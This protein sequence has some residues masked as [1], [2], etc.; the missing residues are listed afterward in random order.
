MPCRMH[1]EYLRRLY[2]NNDLAEGRFEVDLWSPMG[3]DPVEAIEQE[4]GVPVDEV[5]RPVHLRR[6]HPSISSRGAPSRQPRE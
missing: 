5:L 6:D 3:S 4:N 2:L 1:S